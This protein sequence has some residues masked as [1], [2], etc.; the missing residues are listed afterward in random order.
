MNYAIEIGSGAMIYMPSLIRIGL[1]IRKLLG[2][3]H[4]QTQQRD[5]ISLLHIF[6]K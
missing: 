3:I 4:M 2:G 6:F 1:D 5:L